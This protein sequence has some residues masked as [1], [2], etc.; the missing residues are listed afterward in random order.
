MTDTARQI[1]QGNVAL[2]IEF[3]STRI[4]AVLI[5]RDH[6]PLAAGSHQWE[7]RLE[8]GVWTYS[9]EDILGGLQ[10]AYAALK[11]DVLE[12]YGARLRRLGC[13]GVSAMMHGY[14]PLDR[15]GR[16]LTAFR[17]WRNR[18]T[19]QAADE[20]TELF[21]FHIPQRWTIAHLYQ[22]ILNGEE[23]VARI[24]FLTTLEGYVHWLLTGRRVVGVGEGAGIVPTDPALNDY[25]PTMLRLFEEKIA[26]YGYPW[27]L[28]QILPQVLSA[29]E[30]AGFLTEDGALL[31]DPTGDLLPGVS[32]CPPEGDAGTGMTAT[33]CVRPRMANVSA[34]TSI[35][36]M[37]VLE[38]P[39]SRVYPEI[40]LVTTPT[41]RPVAMVHCSN[42]TSDLNAWAG[43]LKEAVEALGQPCDMDKL[44]AALFRQAMLGDKDCGGLV[45]VGY[46]SGENIPRLEEGRP[47]MVRQPESRLSFA[48]FARSLVCS[49]MATLKIGMRLLEEEHVRVDTL[50]GH[51][52]LFKTPG[53]AQRLLASALRAPVSVMETAGEGG[54]WGMALLAAYRLWGREG[55]SLEDYL[56]E[57]VF[58]NARR[59]TEAPDPDDAA[60]F[61]RYLQR[62]ETA[63]ELEREAVRLFPAQAAE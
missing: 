39:L 1:E 47:L 40:D 2:G 20:L 62:F 4:K 33:G 52:G 41:G 60:A 46:F 45:S 9:R 26:S 5:G 11:K 38:K 34:G 35:F 56:E 22:A 43:M 6:A 25:D 59:V 54:A 24:D 61:D 36:S 3:G 18:M 15:E 57:E 19:E 12:R 50:V 7:N 51:G 8:N 48:N 21:Q 32:F 53:T 44:Y 49:S 28:R 58:V 10:S 23:H 17:T 55:Q 30:N 13:M 27:T 42:C 37:A 63:L 29:G 31:L 16:Q 14:L